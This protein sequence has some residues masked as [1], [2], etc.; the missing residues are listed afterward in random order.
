ME[1][2]EGFIIF[3]LAREKAG[4]K[5]G[6]GRWDHIA[7]LRWMIEEAQSIRVDMF[8]CF[9][10]YQKAFDCVDHEK[11][12]IVL[13]QIRVPMHLIILLKELYINQVATVRTEFGKMDTIAIAE[14]CDKDAFF[15]LI[16]WN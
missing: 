1:R 4:F 5:R 3:N 14:G 7:N 8:I 9:I 11:L 15:C 12:W 10:D 13:M 2:F 6:Q 16:N